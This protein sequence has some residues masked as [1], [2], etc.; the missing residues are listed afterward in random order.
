[1]S[2]VDHFKHFNDTYGHQVGDLVLREVAEG[3]K[4]CVRSSDVVARYGGEEMIVLLRGA[5]L[6]NGLVVAEKLR[7]SV[8]GRVVKDENNTYQVTVSLGVATFRA[9][10]TEESVIKRAD[11]GLYKAKNAGRNQVATEEKGVDVPSGLSSKE[12]LLKVVTAECD[13]A[14]TERDKKFSLVLC[15]IDT[16]AGLATGA[17]PD[18]TA[19]E[20]VAILRGSV[21]SSDIVAGFDKDRIALLLN[22]APMEDALAVAEKIRKKIE[23]IELIVDDTKHKITI[24]LG[25]ASFRRH[26][27]TE[28][29]IQR[30]E[31]SLSRAKE[32]GGNRVCA[33]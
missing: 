29:L 30:A 13:M 17:L 6:E 32:E 21:R 7:K 3:L 25:V 9:A 19:K 33:S 23:N 4:A 26:D 24:S 28:P 12:L 22:G 11:A 10:D 2:D 14:T 20:V 8:E 27:K 18:K 5:S 15:Q 16:I 1:M 31:E